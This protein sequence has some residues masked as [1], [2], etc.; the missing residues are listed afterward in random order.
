VPAG[1]LANRSRAALGI[2]PAGITTGL[3]GVWL[4][5]A[6]ERASS[7]LFIRCQ[8]ARPEAEGWRSVA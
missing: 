1:D 6:V 7:P 8:E 3:P 5:S 4:N 2:D